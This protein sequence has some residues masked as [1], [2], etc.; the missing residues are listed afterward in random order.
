ML[1]WNKSP[2]R[3]PGAGARVVSSMEADLKSGPCDR[4]FRRRHSGRDAEP[5]EEDVGRSRLQT[6]GRE[7]PSS[8][9]QTTLIRSC[10]LD[11]DEI[12]CW[13]ACLLRRGLFL[14]EQET[15]LR[16]VHGDPT[17][18]LLAKKKSLLLGRGVL[19]VAVFSASSLWLPLPFW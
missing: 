10:L 19:G 1:F 4:T 8:L 13:R 15:G 12:L 18:P 6:L 9:S 2:N 7:L 17:S 5:P 14:W 3:N 16:I 11:S